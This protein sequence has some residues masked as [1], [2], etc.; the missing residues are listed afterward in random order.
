MQDISMKE[1]EYFM[2]KKGL[3]SK[4]TKV[5]ELRDMQRVLFIEWHLESLFKT[6]VVGDSFSLQ[7]YSTS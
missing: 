1:E 2:K 4:R 7:A 3:K 6:T 5:E